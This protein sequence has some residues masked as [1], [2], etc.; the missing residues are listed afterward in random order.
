MRAG[1]PLTDDDR[2]PWLET[3]AGALHDAADQKGVAVGACSALKRAYRDFLTEKAGEPI[4]FVF[5]DGDIEVIR[6]RIEAR[7]P[8]VHDPQAARQPVRDPGAPGSTTRTCW[9]SDVTDPVETIASRVVKEL[10]HLKTFKR[11]Q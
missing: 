11:G 5:L 10:E 4:L 6:K 8:R 3:L 1:I 2:W 7:A 9:R